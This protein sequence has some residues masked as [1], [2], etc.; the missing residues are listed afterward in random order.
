MNPVFNR[1]KVPST[2]TL[3]RTLRAGARGLVGLLVLVLLRDAGHARH[4]HLHARRARDRD[5][6][7][8]R[9][10][11]PRDRDIRAGNRDH[12]LVPGQSA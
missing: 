10:L 5:R 6:L 11:N 1:L 8:R 7:T 3:R 9:D 2:R 4:R 12:R